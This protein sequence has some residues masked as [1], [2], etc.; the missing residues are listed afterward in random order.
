VGAVARA[1]WGAAAV[2]AAAFAVQGGEYST[3]DLRAQRAR[4]AALLAEVDTLS[5]VVDSL[6]GL[7]RRLRADP[8]LQERVAREEFGM[9]RG[10]KEL[11]YR[12]AEPP[13]AGP[14]AGTAAPGG[15]AAPPR[16]ERGAG[17]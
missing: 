14:A 4:R 16:T 1:V 5:R 7:E 2:S 6:R 11:L 15:A 17:G 12:F 9:V 8:A 3:T 10:D 13:A